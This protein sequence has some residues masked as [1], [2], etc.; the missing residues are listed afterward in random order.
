MSTE[1]GVNQDDAVQPITGD[2]IAANLDSLQA[3][4]FYHHSRFPLTLQ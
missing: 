1:I 4:G 3:A 2:D